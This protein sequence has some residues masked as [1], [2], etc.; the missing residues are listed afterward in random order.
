MTHKPT[1]ESR[2]T[3]QAMAGCGI[4]QADIG[5]VMECSAN[6]LRKH[7]R[8]ELDTG[9][10]IANSQVASTLFKKANGNGP[11]SVTAAIFWLKCRAGWQDKTVI[12]HKGGVS[13]EA[14]AAALENL[15][16]LELRYVRKMATK[17][18]GATTPRPGVDDALN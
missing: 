10:I 16:D 11:A 3:V 18:L 6:T 17:V 12:E 8:T 1:D 9:A 15:S 5:V 7:Y 14:N 4:P 13:V 2:K